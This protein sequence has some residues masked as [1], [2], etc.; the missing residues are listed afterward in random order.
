MKNFTLLILL[1]CMSLSMFSQSIYEEINPI[2]I[3]ELEMKT[4]KDDAEAE[5][6]V[7][8]DY[9]ETYFTPSTEGFDV[10]FKRTTRIKILDESGID[11]AE[12]EILVY[13][14]DGRKEKI[15]SLKGVTYNLVN[16]KMVKT[17]L[18][19]DQVYD[20]KLN[21]YWDLK[22]FAMPNVKPG[23]I[24]EYTY[25][26]TS[27]SFYNFKDWEFQWEIPVVHSEYQV[28]LTP[29]YTYKWILQGAN[30]FYSKKSQ[31][32]T[33][34]DKTIAGI[35][36][37]EMTH[38]YVMKNIPAFKDADFI[39]TKNDFI[40]KMDWQLTRYSDI[41]GIEHKVMSTWEKIAKEYNSDDH[42]GKLINKATKKA[43]KLVDVE[44][45][46]QKSDEEK[47][48]DI[49]TYVKENYEWNGFQS[50][51]AS[52]SLNELLK[53]KT[54]LSADLNLLAIGLLNAVGIEAQGIIL[55]TRKH[56]RVYY[57]YPFTH[58]FNYTLIYA[59]VDGEFILLD[60][61][62]PYRSTWSIPEKCINGKGLLI[63]KGEV[64][65]IP[66]RSTTQSEVIMNLDISFVDDEIL[67]KVKTLYT[68]RKAADKREEVSDET[69]D[70]LEDLMESE[71]V[72][73][74]SIE[75]FKL[76]EIDSDF[77][78]QF[79]Y[80]KEFELGSKKIYF[81]PF[82]DEIMKENPLKE[83][84]REY[85]IDF[86]YSRKVTLISNIEIPEGYQLDYM[87][88]DFKNISNEYFELQYNTSELDGKVK[89][90]LSYW[91]K[92]SVYPSTAYA[93]LKYYFK[94]IIKMGQEKVVFIKQP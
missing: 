44:S 64:E 16:G 89:I 42:Y 25:L 5:A 37:K 34:L 56:G 90:E 18:N 35:K 76:K 87:K 67:S 36:Y 9:G 49:L 23:S 43:V 33:G 78:I 62:N 3:E 93:R 74:E 91:F 1:C 81:S 11:W 50:D 68:G 31:K 46:S 41:R 88:K 27:K 28:K 66:L 29:F 70:P 12:I 10:I 39:T 14:E 65:W 73:E 61:T 54:G 92:R 84:Y 72:D 48:F 26:S 15:S 22:K 63:Q 17:E 21:Q 79:D 32:A 52:Q 59:K 94:D 60:A 57:D 40:V 55:S 53:K 6:I 77:I 51:L 82:F 58:Y 71:G 75:M 69:Y 45:I 2:S 7:L 4:Y 38:N 19:T 30:K 85:P 20:E 8:F 83:K 24:I 13:A 80:I 86:T 47:V